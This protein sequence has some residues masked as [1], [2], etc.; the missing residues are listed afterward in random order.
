[1]KERIRLLDMRRFD[2]ASSLFAPKFVISNQYIKWIKTFT[3]SRNWQQRRRTRVR[4]TWA[5]GESTGAASW[6]SCRSSRRARARSSTH[7]SVRHANDVVNRIWKCEIRE[8]WN[9]FIHCRQRNTLRTTI[10]TNMF[11]K[12][13]TT[14]TTNNAKNSGA[15]VLLQIEIEKKSKSKRRVYRLPCDSNSEYCN[16]LNNYSG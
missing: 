11:S 5:C 7:R 2:I 6:R 9:E 15:N 3:K 12:M 8:K 13:N 4:A 10:A 14:K 16:S 1:M